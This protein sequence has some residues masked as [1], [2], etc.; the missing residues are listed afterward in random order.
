MIKTLKLLKKLSYEVN[1]IQQE[2]ND[3]LYPEL[4]PSKG[5]S[6]GPANDEDVAETKEESR[7][8]EVFMGSIQGINVELV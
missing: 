8:E 5:K 7:T 1:N 2:T 4:I 6:P 3:E